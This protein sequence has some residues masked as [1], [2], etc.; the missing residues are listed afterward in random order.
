MEEECH[1]YG[2]GRDKK[3]RKTEFKRR[4][5]DSVNVDLMEKGQSGEEKQIRALWRPLVRNIKPT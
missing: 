4:W 3:K 2:C 1:E 5:M